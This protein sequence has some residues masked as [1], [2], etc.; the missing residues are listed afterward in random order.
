M[1]VILTNTART[2]IIVIFVLR[3]NSKF[4]ILIFHYLTPS[5][6]KQDVDVALPR[7]CSTCYENF[8]R[9]SSLQTF[10][11]PQ[12]FTIINKVALSLSLNSA[13]LVSLQVRIRKFKFG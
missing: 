3:L 13:T 12:Y 10:I 1:F 7:Y 11:A 5:N 2:E 4:L 9:S 6:G 8:M